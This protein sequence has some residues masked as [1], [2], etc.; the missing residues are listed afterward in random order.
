YREAQWKRKGS[1]ADFLPS[2]SANVNYLTDKKYMLLDTNVG[3]GDITIPQVVPSTQYSL[4][5]A[6][7][8][9]D[10]FSST[11]KLESSEALETS[12]LNELEW[13]RFKINRETVLEFYKTLAAQVLKEVAEQNLKTLQDHLK[14][15][16]AFKKAGVSTNYDV[17]RVEVQVS[18]SSSELL[19]AEDNLAMAR[20]KLGETLGKDNEIRD[21]QGN[22][23]V[24]TESV[25]N[26]IRGE[27]PFYQR[28]DL[29]AL[30]NKSEAIHKH[31]RAVSKFWSPHLALFAEAHYYNNKNDRFDD[32]NSFRNSY[33][34]G[35]NLTWNLFDGLRSVSFSKET[36]E[37]VVQMDKT[38]QLKRIQAKQEYELWK[39]KYRYFC[40]VYNSRHRDISRS[41]EAVRLAK[42]G[43]RAGVR[44]STD[45]LDAESDLFRS[46]AGQIKA[47]I[48]AI[49]ALINLELVSGQK[50]Y[51]F[52]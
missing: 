17:L 11:L 23:P 48:G 51:N 37:Q 21:L 5:A 29:L 22:L 47:Q 12:A 25:L 20:Y 2:I 32:Q 43:R 18:E 6:L 35:V 15:I 9:F 34:V 52:N 26:E 3:G 27:E 49:E 16:Q 4:K 7:P 38:L 33:L 30:Q 28:K 14:D 41:I 39:R 45:L 19:N 40:T 50:L 42:E 1:Y 10:G 46:K 8:L 13:T 36:A 24:L 44:T 31:Y